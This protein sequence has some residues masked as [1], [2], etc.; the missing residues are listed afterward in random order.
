[1]LRELPIAAKKIMTFPKDNYPLEMSYK[2]D[3][4]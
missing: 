2:R 1:M 4:Y 3:Y